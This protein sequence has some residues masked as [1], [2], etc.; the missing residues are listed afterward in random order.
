MENLNPETIVRLRNLFGQMI[1]SRR[2]LRPILSDIAESIDKGFFIDADSEEVHQILKQILEIQ[3]KL[4]SVEQLKKSVATKQLEPIDKSI[5]L[6]EQN[7]KRDEINSTLARIET[8]VVDSEDKAII[9][10]VKKVK[11]QAEHIRIKSG[12]MDSEQFANLAERFIMLAD[13]IDNAEEFSSSEYLKISTS[14]QDNPLI[15]M[16]M[17][18]RLVHFPKVEEIP[19][20][21]PEPP[22]E[23]TGIS[24][25]PNRQKISTVLTKFNKIKPD[26][27]LVLPNIDNFSVQKSAAKKNLSI[28]SFN[29]KIRQLFDS[30]DPLPIFKILTKTRIF[31]IEDPKEIFVHGKITKRIIALVP[32]LMEKLFDWGIV[33]KITWRDRQFYYLNDFGLEICIRNFIHTPVPS[34]GENYFENMMHSLQFSIMFIAEPRI[35][36]KFHFSLTYH[37]TISAARAVVKDGMIWFFSLVLLGEDWMIEI[38]K[39]RILLEK[40]IDSIKAIFLFAFKEEDLKWLE[41]FDYVKIKKIPLYLF[42]FDGLFDRNKNEVD[43]DSWLNDILPPPPL[44]NFFKPETPPAPKSVYKNPPVIDA[45]KILETPKTQKNLFEI[46]ETETISSDEKSEDT[47]AEKPPAAEEIVTIDIGKIEEKFAAT[48]TAEKTTEENLVT[49]D[50]LNIAT[51]LFK[52]GNVA[53]GMLALHALNDFFADTEDEIWADSLTKEIGFILDDP[54]SKTALQ[55]FDTFTFWNAGIEIP[56]T[57]IGSTFDYLNLAATIKNFFAPPKSNNYQLP[58]LWNQI[59]EDKS[60]VALKTCPAAKNLINLFNNFTDN[61]RRAFADSIGNSENSAEDI[62]NAACAQLKNVENIADSLLHS[63]V[64]HRRVK[65]LI[66]QLFKNNGFARKYLY[67][68]NF[69]DEEILNFCQQFSMANLREVINDTGAKVDEETFNEESIS[70]FLDGVWDKPLVT[71]VRREHEHFIGP[72]RK[73]VT[74]VMT[75]ILISLTNYLCAKKNLKSSYKGT[76]AAA[77]VDKALNILEDL[78][79]QIARIEKRGN[80]GIYIFSAFTEN[81]SKRLNGEHF[82]LN[83]NDCLLGANY[84]ELQNNFPATNSFGVEEFSFKNR[85]LEFESDIREKT[86]EENLRRAYET[87]LKTYDGGILISLA[88]NFKNNFGEDELNKKISGVERQVER[89]IERVYNDFLNDLELARNYSRITDQEKIDAYI[90]SIVAAKEH[91]TATKNAG[92][93]QRF[94]NACTESINKT[95]TP[96]KESLNKRLT[97]LEENLEKNLVEGETLETRYPILAQVRRQ[98]DLMNLTVAE[99]YM[100]RL[101]TEGGNLLTELDVTDSNLKT[102]EDFLAEYEVLLH[103]INSTNGSVEAAYKQRAHIFSSSRANRETQNALEFVRGWKE[104]NSG[105]NP[106]IESAI[107]LILEHLGYSG[108][109]ITVR[110][111]NDINQKSYTVSFSEQ[112]KIRDSYPHPFAVFGT[113]IFSKGLEIIYLNTNRNFDNIAQVLS[114]MTSPRGTIVLFNNPMT[115]PQRRALAKTMKLNANLKNIIVIDKVLA[116]YLTRFDDAQRGKKMLQAALPFARVQPYTQG[117]VIAPEMFIGRSEELDQIRDMTGPVFVYGGRQLGKSA[118]LRQV[119]SLEN[120]PAQ[121]NYAFFIDLKN[122]DSEQTLQKIVYELKIAN[123]IVTEIDTWDKFSFEMHKLFDGQLRGVYAPKKLLLLLDESDAFLS[124]KD[125]ETAIDKLRELL[126]TFSGRFKFVLAGLHKVIRF[127]QN[128]SFG[129]LNHISVLPFKPADA[130]ELLVKPMSYLGFKVS[131][132]SLL[133]AIFSRAN[134][135]PGS[136]QYYCKMLVDAVA[137][138]YVK[139]NF[140][141][142]KNPPYTLDDEYLKNMLGNKDFQ[143][144]IDQKFQ[145]TLHLDDDNYYE[146]LAL[147]VAYIYYEHNRPVSV[148]VGE[149]RD[150]CIMCGVDKIT[151]LSDAELLSLLDEMVALNLLRRTDGKFEFNRYAF[152]HMM[153]TESEV[154]DKLDAYG[155]K[156]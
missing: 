70:D 72:K 75:Q 19:E 59:N 79:K 49:A 134:Y 91:F 97:A 55:N 12:K 124:S 69:S 8:L 14:F 141:V 2:Q 96:Q 4:S 129:N 86:F 114:T 65:D 118:L 26:L 125:S 112:V 42:T 110:N 132:D 88:N 37:P 43:F 142:T 119:K 39:F 153:G 148:E 23:N 99:D 152:W 151:K 149:I 29:N 22:P 13:I 136:I 25:S 101:E 131:S 51:N 35:K 116:L 80:L 83:Y 145:I 127:E 81:L 85:F 58:K 45:P 27:A 50:L 137:S 41:L 108:A 94:V 73:K 74:G 93:F 113:E 16:V 40:D 126:V 62:F 90:N 138:N 92:L 120:N 56:K 82:I 147:A 6:L 115:L 122:L 3:Q 87:A 139:Q 34:S 61:T 105:H 155:F 103:A 5:A 66:H 146:I 20:E 52:S 32:R 63:D 60:N 9:D 33:D 130:M 121:L 84:I 128:S 100:N 47:D 17:T 67:V 104:I 98:I 1:H 38:A 53:R 89:Q 78:Q 18:S 117:G 46:E 150:I 77:P 109:K 133:S 135:Y 31:F 30:V 28:K 106:A 154:N 76:Y 57:N 54:I 11:L 143:E 102:L 64:N 71:L 7:S 44:P 144:E 36:G 48:T 140:D 156:A 123:L 21:I 15:A 111:A 95:S 107:I 24:L 68:E 10:A